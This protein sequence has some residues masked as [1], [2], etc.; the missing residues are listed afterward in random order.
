MRKCMQVVAAVVALAASAAGQAASSPPLTLDECIRLAEGAQSNVSIARQQ[1]EIARYGLTQARAGFLPQVHFG[2]GF[3]YNSP[4]A[5]SPDSFSFVAL[6]GLREYSSL[7]STALELDTSGRL[8]AVLARARADQDG[9]AAGLR[10][11]QRELRRAVTAGYYR[12]LLARRL[13]GVSDDALAEA[14]SF[15][16]RTQLLFDNGEA[17]QADV[18]KA[19]AQVAFLDQALNAARLESDLANHALAAFWTTSARAPLAVVDVFDQP[20]LPPETTPAP[21][22]YTSR[23]ELKLLDAEKRGLLADARRAQAELFPQAS[24]VFQYG[25]DSLR[26]HLADR[27][28]A[29]FVNVGLPVFDW[30][31]I[32]SQTRQFELRAQQVETERTM[33]ERAFSKEYQDALA[34]V[35]QFYSQISLAREQVKLSEENLRLARLRYDGGEGLALDVVSAQNQLAQARANYYTALASYQNGRADLEVAS[36]R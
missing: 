9:A 2:G 18:V 14:R 23:P 25:I 22:P 32:H 29:A 7:F 10:I 13:I 11:N 1:A 4:L 26:P 30:L 16:K 12:L 33:A 35:E 5:G 6:N 20:L 31:R 19:K 24:V 3:T 34:R 21:S 36:G 17:A 15:E 28:Y 27:G 8:R